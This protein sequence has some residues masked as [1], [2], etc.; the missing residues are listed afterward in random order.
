MTT[1]RAR[2]LST[3]TVAVAGGAILAA[4]GIGTFAYAAIPDANGVIHGCYARHDSLISGLPTYKGE[5]RV[6]D[7]GVACKASELAL[8]WNAQGV[9]GPAGP[10]GP[11]GLPGQA[12]PPGLTSTYIV[13]KD[14]TLPPNIAVGSRIDCGSDLATGG[15]FS[16]AGSGVDVTESLPETT[17]NWLVTLQNTTGTQRTARV[18]VV[19]ADITP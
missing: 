18:Y 9:A 15:G 5:L 12:G 8:D 13:K 16:G 7:D 17:R 14:V 1:S 3:T 4:A 6:V 2:R 11:Q 19:C 10:Q